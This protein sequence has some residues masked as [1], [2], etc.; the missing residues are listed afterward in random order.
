M[1]SSKQKRRPPGR[2]KKGLN[3]QIK[4]AIEHE[5]SVIVEQALKGFLDFETLE[6]VVRETSLSIGA[7]VLE[8]MIN[9]VNYDIFHSITNPDDGTVLRYV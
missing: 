5:L 9:S 2:L 6:G 7:E 3:S 4:K 1:Q 8:S